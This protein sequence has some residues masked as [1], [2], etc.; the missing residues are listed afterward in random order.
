[1]ILLHL[2][3][4]ALAFA[5]AAFVYSY[6]LTDTGM[7]LSGWYAFLDR[8]I[9][10]AS[11][12]KEWDSIGESF[13]MSKPRAKWLFKLLVGCCKCVTGQ[14]CCWGYFY[15]IAKE[16]PGPYNLIHHIIFITFGIYSVKFI[17]QAY[18]WN[19]NN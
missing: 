15:I 14:F 18:T 13:T 12:V 1:M 19:P 3:P 8:M 7:I 2:L 11:S 4:W 16:V 10:P 9:G 5:V 6:V 17:A